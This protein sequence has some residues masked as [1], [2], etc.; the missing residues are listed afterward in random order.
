MPAAK[1]PISAIGLRK[2][3]ACNPSEEHLV[4]V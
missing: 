1:S 3:K 2:V 4:Y